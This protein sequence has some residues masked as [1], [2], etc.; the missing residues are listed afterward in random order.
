MRDYAD[1]TIRESLLQP[2]NLRDFVHARVPHL[3]DRFDF[4]QR[5]FIPPQVLLPDGRGRETDLAFEIPYRF[6]SEEKTALVLVLIEHQTRASRFATLR[7][8]LYISLYWDKQWSA[9][10]NLPSPKSE[11][12]LSPVLPIV[13]HTGT[14]PWQGGRSINDMLGEPGDF[15]AFAPQWAPLF[16]ELSEHSVDEL[17][18]RDEAFLHALA[19]ADEKRGHRK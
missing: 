14:Q 15:H 13:F 4:A 12:R 10:E 8:L 16:W 5:K 18:S 6:G 7:M 19:V 3:A 11:F 9:W 2:E 17:L 1:K